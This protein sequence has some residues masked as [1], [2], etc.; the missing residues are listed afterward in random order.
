MD[1][2]DILDP[3]RPHDNQAD[4]SGQHDAVSSGPRVQD[5]RTQLSVGI[6]I[7]SASTQVV[8]SRMRLHRLS[9]E[10]TGRSCVAGHEPVY[11]SPVVLT[12][13]VREEHIDGQ[14]IGRFV[15]E[16]HTLAD[17]D[18]DTVDTGAVMLTGEAQRRENVTAIADALGKRGEKFLWVAA[19]HHT[20][21]MLAAYGSGAAEA[22]R[23]CGAPVLNIDIGGSTTK[24][25][26]V[27]GGDVL[28]AA[29]MQI[30][31]RLAV[32]DGEACLTRLNPAGGRLAALA[33]CNWAAGKKVSEHDV[34]RVTAWMADAL[35]AVLSETASSQIH[36]L[37]LTEPLPAM[38]ATQG[39]MFSGGVGE[40]VYGREERDFGDLGRRF[41]RAIRQR[42]VA[43]RFPFPLLPVGEGI[44][45]TALGAAKHSTRLS[46]N[47]VYLSR[48][49]ALLPRRNL[50]VIQPPMVLDDVID[51][52]TV[53]AAIRS[54]FRRFDLEEGEA[55]IALAFRW[56]GAPSHRR[57][58]AFAKSI[59]DAMSRTVAAGKSLFVM[60]DADVAQTLGT[61]LK[62]EIGV[63][64]EVLVLD[65]IGARDFD[66]VDLGCVSPPSSAV[67]VTVTSLFFK[68]DPRAPM[69][70]HGRDDGQASA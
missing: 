65:G 4:V 62:A 59:V 30:G 49:D 1:M 11:Q 19:G 6:D 32:L 47:T 28:H 3:A 61:I 52:E 12:P 40:Y 51:T 20:E 38:R 70:A 63:A 26:L 55:E 58:A 8:F 29:A 27:Q 18:P 67:P 16:A 68:N 25:T 44:R 2:T 37:W 60:L 24:L 56:R 5:D 69:R 43:G 48:P 21:A 14:A 54:H 39:V 35:V 34:E 57:L 45:A 53:T 41:G 36:A 50:Q 13:Y 66:Y 64:S 7:G 10:P 22:S 42:L 31:A 46:G 15:D 17:I 33:G 9:E 23:E